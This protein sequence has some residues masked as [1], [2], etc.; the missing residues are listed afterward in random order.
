[1]IEAEARLPPRTLSTCAEITKAVAPVHEPISSNLFQKSARHRP[2]CTQVPPA[3]YCD[4]SRK[5]QVRG[6]FI[7]GAEQGIG[8]RETFPIVPPATGKVIAHAAQSTEEDV[9]VGAEGARRLSIGLI[10][11]T[12]QSEHG[13]N[14]SISSA[15][16]WRN[17]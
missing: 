15:M 9:H 1:M 16:N 5:E 14:W 11:R 8:E 3:K 7:D 12:Y 17:I 2:S 13:P 4:Q 10:G 6:L